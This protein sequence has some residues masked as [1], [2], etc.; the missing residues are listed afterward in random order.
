MIFNGWEDQLAF[1]LPSKSF[2]LI[3]FGTAYAVVLLAWFFARFAQR[4]RARKECLAALVLLVQ[5]SHPQTLAHLERVSIAAQ[6]LAINLGLSRSRAR[7][8]GYAALLHDIGKIAID[9][10]IL[11]KPSRLTPE[12]RLTVQMHPAAGAMILGEMDDYKLIAEWIRLHHERLDGKGY[13]LG[14]TDPF[15]PIE[16]RIISVVDAF[17]A[18]TESSDS[19]NSRPYRVPKSNSDALVELEGC[20]GTQFCSKVVGEYV[21]LWKEGSVA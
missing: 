11:D 21:Q 12:E 15:I 14:L 2:A 6:K 19:L 13:P 3:A 9:E 1:Y 5:Q 7:L 20:S 4:Q 16:A 18:M 8:V 10:K 17:D